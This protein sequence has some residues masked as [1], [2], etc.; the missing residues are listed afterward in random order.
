M[1]SSKLW[2]GVL[3]LAGLA[4]LGGCG[5]EQEAPMYYLR[6]GEPIRLTE[7]ADGYDVEKLGPP[8]SD[9][10]YRWEFEAEREGDRIILAARAFVPEKE[11]PKTRSWY[12]LEE[13]PTGL[14]YDAIGRAVYYWGGYLPSKEEILESFEHSE[15]RVEL[16]MMEIHDPKF[17]DLFAAWREGRFEEAEALATDLAQ[18]H[19][20]DRLFR[21]AEIDA[22]MGVENEVRYD[23][24]IDS[25]AR[26]FEATGLQ[27][28]QLAIEAMR[29]TQD[30][31]RLDREGKNLCSILESEDD[32]DSGSSE[33]IEEMMEH[34]RSLT[35]E[36][37]TCNSKN[38][39]ILTDNDDLPKYLNLAMRA[40]LARVIADSRMLQ[41]KVDGPIHTLKG[42]WQAGLLFS[43]DRDD[44]IDDLIGI[45]VRSISIRGIETVYLNAMTTS[46][47]IAYFFPVINDAYKQELKIQGRKPG[48]TWDFWQ[49]ERWNRLEYD[50]RKKVSLTHTALVHSAAPVKHRLFRSGEFP[51]SPRDFAPLLPAGPDP[52]PFDPEGRRLRTRLVPERENVFT[53]YSLGPDEADQQ[54]TFSYDPTNGTISAGDIFTDIPREREYPFPP[55]GELATTAPELLKQFPNGLP[56]DPFARNR[57]ASYT[58]THTDP[59]LILSVGPNMDAEEESS[60]VIDSLVDQAHRIKKGD[61]IATLGRQYILRDTMLLDAPY[62]P[63]NGIRSD[64]DLFFNMADPS[65]RTPPFRNQE[66]EQ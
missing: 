30:A 6:L 39:L 45:A 36:Y 60:Q 25:Y 44:I 51:S 28:D 5:E 33:S 31:R 40:K 23:R 46:D 47:Q 8:D 57:I 37:T 12:L 27:V 62:D 38:H 17:L 53:I 66:F 64:G 19:P 55:P 11:E 7:T 29:K 35:P 59:A 10:E 48:Q 61:G 15:G 56:P 1:K 20:E 65:D 2:I 52:D 22:A 34:F 9:L 58:I 49:I 18:R 24:L 14:G 50:T 42:S 3:L 21:L 54:A 43:R 41:G 26:E 4:C 63:T 32:S 16:F 13:S